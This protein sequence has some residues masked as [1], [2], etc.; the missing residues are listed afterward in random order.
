MD[1]VLN[2]HMVIKSYDSPDYQFVCFVERVW[3]WSEWREASKGLHPVRKGC[4]SV[5]LLTVQEF[6]DAVT[7]LQTKGYLVIL[8]ID[9]VYKEYGKS[10]SVKAILDAIIADKHKRNERF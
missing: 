1:M 9:E 10:Y 3:S 4:K 7:S 6:W 2:W 5:C 8:G